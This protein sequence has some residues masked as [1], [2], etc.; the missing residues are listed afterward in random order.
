MA[1][2]RPAFFVLFLGFGTASAAPNTDG[3]ASLPSDPS[4]IVEVEARTSFRDTVD[5]I[6]RAIREK[7]LNLFTEIDHAANA[8]NAGLDLG[9]THLF[10][11][12]NPKVGTKLMQAARTVAMDLPQKILVYED[13]RGV[14]VVFNAPEWLGQ[15]HGFESPALPKIGKLLEGLASGNPNP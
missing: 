2:M 3:P 5:G 1:F 7:G 4:G 8:E 6:R 14:H 10:I 13:A 12:G 9:P 15:R 11:F